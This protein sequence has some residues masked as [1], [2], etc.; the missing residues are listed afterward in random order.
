MVAFGENCG[1]NVKLRVRGLKRHILA[2]NRVF[3]RFL[4]QSRCG[5]L[6]CRR[7][8]E[9]PKNEKI[10]KTKGCA[11]SHMRRYNT[12]YLICMKFCTVVG[13]PDIITH[14]NYGYDRLRGFWVA[15][16]SNFPIPH[17]LSLSSLQHSHTTVQRC[18]IHC[19]TFNL[20]GGARSGLV[21]LNGV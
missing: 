3:W 20:P 10:A 1:L 19:P 2:Q 15:G 9:P 21:Q 13:I 6:G 7:L 5:R 4:C 17:R 14:A 16:G 11:K 8:A 18:R 12:P